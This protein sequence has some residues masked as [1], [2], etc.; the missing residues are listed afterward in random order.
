MRT[1]KS[2]QEQ[3][4]DIVE[5]A[6]AKVEKQYKEVADVSFTYAEKLTNVKAV[7][8][9]HDEIADLAYGKAHKVNKLIG[10]K[11]GELI[12]KFEKPQS[13]TDKVKATAKKAAT[14]AKKQASAAK[15][16]TAKATK[17]VAKKIEEVTA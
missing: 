14:T 11:A 3:A 10:E 16:A 2:F 6:I 7:K 15:T 4:Q 5:N 13:T 1:I 9:K 8:N 12:S 17:K